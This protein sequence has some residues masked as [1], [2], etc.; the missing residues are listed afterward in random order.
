MKEM[1]KSEVSIIIPAYQPDDKMINVIKNL[2]KVGFSDLLVVDDGSEESH[3]H[4]F[5]EN[6]TIIGLLEQYNRILSASNNRIA[7]PLP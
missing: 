5:E 3:N 1:S 2:V 6:S 7:V 4:I